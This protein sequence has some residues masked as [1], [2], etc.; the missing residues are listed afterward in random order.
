MSST[1]I[2]TAG[3]TRSRAS[4]VSVPSAQRFSTA[5]P[6]GLGP[7]VCPVA[8]FAAPVPAGRLAELRASRFPLAIFTRIGVPAGV[9]VLTW[10][11]PAYVRMGVGVFLIL[12]SLY[13]WFRPA[14]K[15][16]MA[17]VFCIGT[18]T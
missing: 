12:Y 16:V 10:A 7:C 3:T 1:S 5:A 6:A 11:N 13:A 2:T 8:P 9:A 17:S 4:A 15:P 14:L 18:A